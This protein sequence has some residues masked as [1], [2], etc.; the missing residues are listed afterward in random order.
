M[1]YNLGQEQVQKTKA[2]RTVGPD[3]QN[4]YITHASLSVD[5]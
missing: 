2:E 1:W 5:R 4:T 3:A